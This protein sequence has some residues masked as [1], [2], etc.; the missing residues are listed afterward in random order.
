MYTFA[1]GLLLSLLSCSGEP[2]VSYPITGTVVQVKGGSVVLDHEEIPGFMQAMVMDLPAAPQELAR[3]ATGDQV[4]GLL[5]VRGEK[6]FLSEL[7]VTAR[8]QPVVQPTSGAQGLAVGDTLPAQQIPVHGGQPLTL[9]AGQGQV[10]LLTFLFTTCP[11]PEYC[12]L[13]ATKLVGLQGDLGGARI[14]AITLDPETDTLEVLR[15][16][17]ETV[18]ADPAVWSFGRLETPALQDLLDLLGVKRIPS[19]GTLMH[20]MRILVL[21]GAGQIVHVEKDNNWEQEALLA[22]VQAVSA[23]KQP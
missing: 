13:L 10:T 8:D 14:L 22:Q 23:P 12:P 16:Y 5:V 9:G 20:S 3:L 1:L 2:D 21:D 17:G 19:K 15:S 11:L 4:E 18:G 7:V 6:A